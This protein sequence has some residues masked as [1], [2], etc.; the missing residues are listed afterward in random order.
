MIGDPG[1]RSDGAQPARPRHPRPQP[2]GHHGPARAAPRLRRRARPGPP[3]R[4]PR[5]D[6]ADGRARVPPRR[7][8]ARHGEHRCWPR[9]RCRA[10]VESEPASRSPS[11]ATC[12]CRPTTT[13][14]CTSTMGVEL[15]VGG[16]DQ[17]GN[18]TAGIDLIRRTSGGHVHGLTV[19]AGD[20]GRRPEVRQ[21]GRRGRCGSSAERTTP[22]AFYQYFVN[23]DDRDVERFLLQ[24]TLL[25]VAEVAEVM[26]APRRGARAAGGPAGAGRGRSPPWCTATTRP[27]G[28]PGPARASPAPPPSSTAGEWAELAA[29]L[30]TVALGPDDL[31]RPLVDLLVEHDGPDVQERGAAPGR[32]GRALPQRRRRCPPTAL[33]GADDLVDGRLGHGPQGQEAAPCPPSDRRL[34]T[35]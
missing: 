22:Y 3:G 33:L 10:R 13:G 23:V 14:T 24:L 7:R 5:L 27:S 1:G 15:Q 2:G 32:P 28:P 29:S 19:P 4:Q 31:G 9:S 17:W 20:P 12:S 30:P 34:T 16:S 18:I 35:P 26:A 25:P 6:R 11:S 8:Q 21:V